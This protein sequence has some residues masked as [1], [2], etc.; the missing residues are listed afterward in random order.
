M[1]KV[2]KTEVVC[3]YCLGLGIIQDE[4]PSMGISKCKNCNGTGTNKQQK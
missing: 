1:K 3:P 4:F 2:D